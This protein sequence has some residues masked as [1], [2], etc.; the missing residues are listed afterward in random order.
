MRSIRVWLVGALVGSGTGLS[1]FFATQMMSL[2]DELTLPE[3]GVALI[4][5]AVVAVLVARVT[6][7]KM[8]NSMVVAYLT[9]VFPLIG[10]LFGAPDTNLMVVVSLALLGLAGGLVWS[11]PFA[12]WTLIRRRRD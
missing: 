1:T 12:L 9:L 7:S 8:V 4:A 10:A 3:L 6:G 5:P 11:T 2:D